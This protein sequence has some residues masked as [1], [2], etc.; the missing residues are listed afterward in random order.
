VSRWF[1]VLF[2]WAAG[3]AERQL[4]ATAAEI[5]GVLGNTRTHGIFKDARTK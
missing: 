1:R 2:R 3:F 5:E 4:N